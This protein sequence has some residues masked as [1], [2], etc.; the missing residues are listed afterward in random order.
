M[1]E[2]AKTLVP[3]FLLGLSPIWIPLAV[4][5]VGRINDRRARRREPPAE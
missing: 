5:I 2:L 4:E 3:L 1:L